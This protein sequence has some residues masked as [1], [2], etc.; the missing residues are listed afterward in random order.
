MQSS[1]IKAVL[2]IFITILIVGCSSK[3]EAFAQL[4]RNKSSYNKLKMTKTVLVK[5]AIVHV[6]YNK[7]SN[8]FKVELNSRDREVDISLQKCLINKKEA[9]VEPSS[10]SYKWQNSYIVYSSTSTNKSN[11][12][13][14]TLNSGDRFSLTF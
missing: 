9:I 12:L 5:S 10:S 4:N 14:C 3:N 6:T 8:N 2:Y 13:S 7:K 1:T 11:L